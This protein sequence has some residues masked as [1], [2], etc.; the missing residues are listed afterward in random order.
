MSLGPSGSILFYKKQCF[1]HWKNRQEVQVQCS[2]GTAEGGRL[3]TGV[4]TEWH[5][6]HFSSKVARDMASAKLLPDLLIFFQERPEIS[7]YI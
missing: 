7:I 3:G 4:K 2:Q 5:L 6:I 1:P